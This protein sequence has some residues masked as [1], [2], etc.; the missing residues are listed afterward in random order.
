AARTPWVSRTREKSSRVTHVLRV[1]RMQLYML[2]T[3][4]IEARRVVQNVFATRARLSYNARHLGVLMSAER[5]HRAARA[6]WYAACALLA[7]CA[8]GAHAQSE[9]RD[10]H[11]AARAFAEA[12]RAQL[13]G[14]AESAARLYELADSIAPTP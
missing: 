9:Q 6:S 1:R 8:S 13:R 5:R 3:H 7:L 11:A 12:Q 14:D 10:V 4:A 2:C